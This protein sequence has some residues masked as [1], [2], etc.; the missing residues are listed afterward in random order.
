MILSVPNQI[1]EKQV[2][3]YIIK[4]SSAVSDSY[5]SQ[6]PPDSVYAFYEREPQPVIDSIY[7]FYGN[8][9]Q[10]VTDSIYEILI[11]PLAFPEKPP[12]YRYEAKPKAQYIQNWSILIFVLLFV[13]LATVR[14]SSE[15]Y[16]IQLFQSIFNRSTANRLFREKVS[17]FM[18]VSF[19]LDTFFILVIGLL[20]YQTV[21]FVVQP[22]SEESIIYFG[23]S[24]AAILL[25]VTVKFSFYRIIGF[26]FDV[27]SETQEYI[28][29]AKSGNRIMGLI[30]FPIVISLFF[31]RGNYAEYLLII[32]GIIVLIASII[33]ILRGMKVIAQKVFSIYYMILYLCTL[34]IL[35]L[36]LMW[37]I[38]WRT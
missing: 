5:S 15:K 7:T 10:P 25:Y 9:P 35:P 31:I 23:I 17:N 3:F 2:E 18:H 28:F 4:D 29:Y 30:L 37:R 38:L 19:R 14:T 24:V 8:E 13:I 16:I 21:N 11:N 12:G 26:I 34:E 22:T 33:N 36:L 1:P 6:N 20:I 27:S 32:G